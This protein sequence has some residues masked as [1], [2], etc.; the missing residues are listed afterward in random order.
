MRPPRRSTAA[1]VTHRPRAGDA[2]LGAA[3][4]PRTGGVADRVALPWPRKR[5]LI[6][7]SDRLPP[8]HNPFRC[9]HGDRHSA[10]V[11][12]AAP[13]STHPVTG[14]PCL[15][16]ARQLELN[17]EHDNALTETDRAACG[18]HAGR[19][20]LVCAVQVE[21]VERPELRWTY[22]TLEWAADTVG[23][24]AAETRWLSALLCDP[25]RWDGTSSHLTNGQHR[26]CAILHSGA[27]RCAV[28]A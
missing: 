22:A 15:S 12:A 16:A 18:Y 13:D 9:P 10:L 17:R 3:A 21:L 27:P 14:A 28:H 8:A 6:V 24:T 20:P 19:W 7:D 23:L 4:P 1:C 25:L 11:A 2:L 26:A 5:F